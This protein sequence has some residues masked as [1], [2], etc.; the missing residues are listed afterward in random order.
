MLCKAITT[1]ACASTLVQF[2]KIAE[3]VCRGV[4]AQ[5]S[6]KSHGGFLA[7]FGPSVTAAREVYC[8][9]RADQVL[10]KYS[11]HRPH[12]VEVTCLRD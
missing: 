10:D 8:K 6:V 11:V 2:T 1:S 12:F 3:S 4:S 5:V 9:P 7:S